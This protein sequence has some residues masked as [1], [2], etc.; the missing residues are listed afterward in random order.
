MLTVFEA[1]LGVGF[2]GLRSVIW[3]RRSRFPGSAPN[4][5]TNTFLSI[6]VNHSQLA[7]IFSSETSHIIFREP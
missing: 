3:G 2:K 6:Y 5:E 4:I 1:Q 7:R